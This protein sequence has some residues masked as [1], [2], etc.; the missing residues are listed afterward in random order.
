MSPIAAVSQ[1]WLT[2]AD[3]DLD[4][5]RALVE[6]DT[7]PADHPSAERVE[8]NVP[9]YDSDR[10]RALT[11]TPQGRRE[12]QAE[13]VR[14]LLDGPGIVVF[15]GAFSD[16]A[17]VDRASAVFRELIEEER[18]SGT[19][20][21][22]HFARPGANDRVWRALDKMAVRAPDVF[23]D[24]YAN[25]MLALVAEAW[26]GPAY[27]VTSQVN[28]VNPG[29]AAQSPHRDYHLGFLSQR[30]AAAYPAHVHRLSPALTLQGAVAHC[31]MPVESGPTLY[32][33]HSQKFE[34]GYLA[35]RLAEF[36]GYFDAHHVQL[37][38]DK[39]DAAFFNPALFH[40]AGHNR[41]SD[42]R[43]MANLLQISSAFGR[44]METVDRE[45]MV[46]AVFPVLL[47][48]RSEGASDDWLRRVVAATAEGYPFPTDLDLDP[49][50]D[51]L[52][53]PSQADLLRQAVSEAWDPERLGRELEAVGRRRGHRTDR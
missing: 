23:A 40:A 44:A 37:P 6:Q 12:I 31:D 24:Y 53:P 14:T 18:A 15:K 4:T 48:R 36:V 51:G 43:R 16:P 33:P 1:T 26:L 9:L 3:C 7:A 25:D 39:G 34:P 45:A 17:V 29:G 46:N 27:Q 11:A 52:A 8:H 28:V 38:L 19:A 41:S 47:R 35:W 42:I 22:D 10:L 2:E 21:G 13:L 20:R 32:L 49:P 50:V 30:Q 5:F